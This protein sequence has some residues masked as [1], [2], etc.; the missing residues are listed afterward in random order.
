MY[1]NMRIV[2]VSGLPCPRSIWALEFPYTHGINAK[3]FVCLIPAFYVWTKRHIIWTKHI[4]VCA[5][6]KYTIE[7]K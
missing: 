7:P 3:I 1:F 4:Y 2:I 5:K 6:K